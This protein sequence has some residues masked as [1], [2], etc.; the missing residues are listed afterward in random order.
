M[1]RQPVPDPYEELR[2]L[3][4]RLAELEAIAALPDM[5]NRQIAAVA[6]VDRRTVDRARGAFAPPEPDAEPARVI[7]ADGKS[8]PGRVV[9]LHHPVDEAH[10]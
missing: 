1:K 6:G 5:S 3:K 2:R 9:G 4:T 10:S 8:Y 7:G